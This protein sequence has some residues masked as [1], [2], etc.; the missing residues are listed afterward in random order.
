MSP[1]ASV[2]IRDPLTDIDVGVALAEYDSYRESNSLHR[3]DARLLAPLE[4][5]FSPYSVDFVFLQEHHSVFQMEALPVDAC[6]LQPTTT[7]SI[8]RRKSRAGLRTSVLCLTCTLKTPPRSSEDARPG[9]EW[10]R[11]AMV[12]ERR[13]MERLDL[14]SASIAR[15]DVSDREPLNIVSENLPD[16]ARF[17]AQ[18]DDYLKR[19]EAS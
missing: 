13:V 10:G 5:L 2:S 7:G 15:M 16:L 1:A 4:D 18:V 8:M 19:F 3:I 14:I 11:S 12:S 17:V 6:T 9:L